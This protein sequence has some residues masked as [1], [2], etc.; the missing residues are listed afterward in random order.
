MREV[1]V[2]ISLCDRI[3]RYVDTLVGYLPPWVFTFVKGVFG[4]TVGDVMM[5]RKHKSIL[6]DEELK[7]DLEGLDSVVLE[8]LVNDFLPADLTYKMYKDFTA[9]K[10]VI[11]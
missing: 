1:M 10:M 4:R 6:L 11:S 2:D 3:V 9:L 5:R 7:T 8:I